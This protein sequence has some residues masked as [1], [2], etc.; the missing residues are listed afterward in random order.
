LMLRMA[1]HFDGGT[2]HA[3]KIKNARPAFEVW[4]K[5]ISELPPGCQQITGHI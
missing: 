3:K 1:T 5:E 2:L 4:E